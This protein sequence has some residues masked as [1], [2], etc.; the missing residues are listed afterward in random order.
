MENGKSATEAG[1]LEPVPLVTTVFHENILS[2][3]RC[4][5]MYPDS[6]QC[7]TYSS[8]CLVKNPTLQDKYSAF[9][10]QKK[11]EGYTER[12]LEES[13]GF[14][15]FDEEIKAKQLCES[16]IEVDQSALST[17]GDPSKGV[18]ISKYSDCLDLNPWYHGKTGFIV[19]FRLTKGRVKEVTE[20]YTQNFTQP[21]VGFDCHI[22][23]QI[24]TVSAT[25]S[26][27]LAYERTQ[28]YVY[29]L[30]SGGEAVTRPRQVCPFAVIRFSYGKTMPS[31]TNLMEQRY[32]P[33][34]GVFQY[35]LWQ[36][37]LQIHSVT[38]PVALRSRCD[39]LLP[40][41]LPTT[42]EMS[43]SISVSDLKQ[44]LLQSNFETCF[45][46]E[47]LRGNGCNFYTIIPLAD[48]DKHTLLSLELKDKDLALVLQ[49]KD[50]GFLV[51]LHSSTFF[52]YEDT[53]S[54]QEDSLQALFLFPDSR[55]VQKDTKS[56]WSKSLLSPE[57][58][59]ALPGFSYAVTKAE[60]CPLNQQ[61]SISC[62]VEQHLQSYA[63]L[64]QP[65]MHY[66]PSREISVFPDQ[67][68]VP[69]VIGYLYSA[70]KWTETS[71]LQ[72]L[73][74]FKQPGNYTLPV[75][76]VTELLEAGRDESINDQGNDIYY[77]L[78]SPENAGVTSSDFC[79]NGGSEGGFRKIP[80]QADVV[81]GSATNERGEFWMNE[82][83]QEGMVAEVESI[84]GVSQS[85]AP[86]DLMKC[87]GLGIASFDHTKKMPESVTF[88]AIGEATPVQT[89]DE[90]E[91][92]T[93]QEGY[94]TEASV[95][96]VSSTEMPDLRFVQHS[97]TAQEINSLP[98]TKPGVN[99]SFKK[100]SRRGRR[101]RKRGR[102]ANSYPQENCVEALTQPHLP[103]RRLYQYGLKTI[104]TD[105]GK[106]FVPHG[107]EIPPGDI[108][109]MAEMG[110]AVAV[111]SN[112]AQLP[113]ESSGISLIPARNAHAQDLATGTTDKRP[114]LTEVVDE[115]NL[116][117][118]TDEQDTVMETTDA[119]V[120]S[121]G[122][123]DEQT[124]YLETVD[125]QVIPL[126]I[127]DRE[128]MPLNREEGLYLKA[129]KVL[130][131]TVSSS[132]AESNQNK[133]VQQQVVPST[134]CTEKKLLGMTPT[135]ERTNGQKGKRKK[136]LCPI[137]QVSSLL[138]ELRDLPGLSTTELRTKR[139]KSHKTANEVENV[140]VNC[141]NTIAN[142]LKSDPKLRNC[143]SFD[144]EI[145][146]VS[147]TEGNPKTRA[148]SRKSIPR[149]LDLANASALSDGTQEISKNLATPTGPTETEKLVKP[150]KKRLRHKIT[151]HMKENGLLSFDTST[152]YGSDN[153]S[154]LQAQGHNSAASGGWGGV[155]NGTS[156]VAHRSSETGPCQP[157]D[158]LSMLADL[159]LSNNG[160]KV[161]ESQV[162][163]SKLAV[164]GQDCGKSMDDGPS[165]SGSVLSKMP[166]H[167]LRR[168]KRQ[169]SKQKLPARSPSPK[170]LV[171]TGEN[172]LV[173]SE[174]HSYSLSP[175]CLL[176]GLSGPVLQ[177]PHLD[178]LDHPGNNSSDCLPTSKKSNSSTSCQ[179]GQGGQDV[180]KPSAES[181]MRQF[182]PKDRRKRLTRVRQVKEVYGSLKVSRVW[183]EKYEFHLDSKYTNNL[184]EKAVMR[185]LHGPWDYSIEETFEQIRLIL[186]MWIGLF[187]SRS[188][189]RFFEID[190]TGDILRGPSSTDG[191]HGAAPDPQSRLSVSEVFY[192]VPSP[193]PSPEP[194]ALDLRE[195]RKKLTD[196]ISTHSDV[197]DLSYNHSQVLDL[198]ISKNGTE[199]P[200]HEVN[201]R[202]PLK[203]LC[204]LGELDTKDPLQS[205]YVTTFHLKVYRGRANMMSDEENEH[206]DDGSSVHEGGELDWQ[207][208][209]DSLRN[210]TAYNKLCDHT[211][212]ICI[213]S[214]K[215]LRTQDIVQAKAGNS[216]FDCQFEELPVKE[217][218]GTAEL[219]QS[220]TSYIQS[221]KFT[222][223]SFSP[224]VA[225]PSVC[226]D[227]TK[228]DDYVSNTN[229]HTDFC[230]VN[231]HCCKAL[232]VMPANSC[233]DNEVHGCSS[234]AV[235]P[236]K[237]HTRA[238][239]AEVPQ[240][241]K[242]NTRKKVDFSENSS[243]ESTDPVLE[244]E[245]YNRSV[246]ADKASPPVLGD[247]SFNHE[248]SLS[249]CAYI[250][251][252][253][254][255][256]A[257]TWSSSK[258]TLSVES[259][260]SGIKIPTSIPICD[261]AKSDAVNIATSSLQNDLKSYPDNFELV[262]S[263]STNAEKLLLSD[264]QN[265]A[266]CTLSTTEHPQ[267]GICEPY[268]FKNHDLTDFSALSSLGTLCS[269]KNGKPGDQSSPASCED[270][271][272]QKNFKLNLRDIL[273][274]SDGISSFN[275]K[276]TATQDLNSEIGG[277][278]KSS[279]KSAECQQCC[280]GVSSA[281][282]TTSFESSSPSCKATSADDSSESRSTF[283]P[284][285]K[286]KSPAPKFGPHLHF[287]G[288]SM[289]LSK[290]LQSSLVCMGQP[291]NV[292]EQDP[293]VHSSSMYDHREDS[294]E[295]PRSSAVDRNSVM[296]EQMEFEVNS[297]YLT[298]APFHH[299]HD[300]NTKFSSSEKLSH[301][302]SLDAS[303]F[304]TGDKNDFDPFTNS[305]IILSDNWQL[306]YQETQSNCSVLS[307]K[308]SLQKELSLQTK[309][310][311]KKNLEEKS[312]RYHTTEKIQPSCSKE[313]SQIC[314]YDSASCGTHPSPQDILNKAHSIKHCPV[315]AVKPSK[316]RE[317][318]GG[319]DICETPQCETSKC[320][321]G[322]EGWVDAEARLTSVDQL[323]KCDDQ[324]HVEIE[325]GVSYDDSG[326][327]E[328]AQ[329]S[330]SC[331]IDHYDS[332]PQSNMYNPGNM[333]DFSNARHCSSLFDQEDIN[334]HIDKEMLD[335]SKENSGCFSFRK[336]ELP[337]TSSTEGDRYETQ[338]SSNSKNYRKGLLTRTLVHIKDEKECSTP[339]LATS[340][341]TVLDSKGRRV[342]Y[343]NC[344]T[345]K[346]VS[347]RHVRTIQNTNMV[348]SPLQNFLQKWE[349]MH[350]TKP[351]ITQDT[352]D[353]EYLIFSEKMNQIL[354]RNLRN[355]ASCRPSRY[356][357]RHQLISNADTGPCN[358]PG[359]ERLSETGGRV[360][361]DYH[362][363]QS[364]FTKCKINMDFTK[365]T[366]SKELTSYFP[367][368][369]CKPPWHLDR[370][371]YLNRT[372]YVHPG[373]SSIT[374]ECSSSYQTVM[375][376]ICSSRMFLQ[377]AKKPKMDSKFLPQEMSEQP[378]LCCQTKQE[379][380]TNLQEQL[381][382]VVRQ[383][384]KTKFRFYILVT[385]EDGFFE[386]TKEVLEA[387]GHVS[388]DPEQFEVGLQ[389]TAMPL[390]I[391]L[392]NEDIAEYICTIP[393]LL[394]L[395]K[396][397]SV[398]FA[399]I[400]QPDDVLNLT[401]QELFN[402][403]G[404]VVCDSAMLDSLMLDNMKTLIEFLEKLSSS[405]KWTWFLHYRDCRLFKEK[406]RTSMD[407]KKRKQF[408]DWCQEAGIVETLPYH[409]CDILSGGQPDYLSCLLHLQA[410]HATARFAVFITDTPD[411][412]FGMYGIFVMKI[413]AFLQIY[414]NNTGKVC[415][416]VL[417][418]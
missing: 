305:K 288:S 367:F 273:P 175:S 61:E 327:V 416:S 85:A 278:H 220:R 244:P 260:S 187:Y 406:Q 229:I 225:A 399:G 355:T 319:D 337:F 9:C 289:N 115:Q 277:C 118:Q 221:C 58:I 158:A 351:D 7:F 119:Q 304:L 26:S 43:N 256:H 227:N 77:C 34:T 218:Q 109:F 94:S 116:P 28:Y 22:S 350:L 57:I 23:E 108:K 286:P 239:E 372:N 112:L 137:S 54:S 133:G 188:T 123:V 142:I 96:N 40:A 251:A 166:R 339:A 131:S 36:G 287:S 136:P 180:T 398:L 55:L 322:M 268:T 226:G 297:R 232:A 389:S 157:P 111:E 364:P 313:H 50:S 328:T 99:A 387:E 258:A 235:Q 267:G 207:N 317:C 383:S 3:L 233:E 41:Q 294:S 202:E 81:E 210:D 238:L 411:D 70:P 302:P 409:E 340:I 16:G 209:T 404:F 307:R 59:K 44:W 103:K 144:A 413:N 318:R 236:D 186:H 386:Q 396:T 296:S 410:Q 261:Q 205:S 213:A 301:Q 113:A 357:W 129:N 143:L 363:T 272:E 106:I 14:L 359:I 366:G 408:L 74:Y 71:H 393:R 121:T 376:D 242:S 195:E 368:V 125:G 178:L 105:C 2:P 276:L 373:V 17:L 114:L 73:S 162:P 181:S 311:L 5:Y 344:P 124:Q 10:T 65:G 349:K 370:L 414:R 198:T 169:I 308:T 76:R 149:K 281:N 407:A 403:G 191:L 280:D 47:V 385:S 20:N 88:T 255:N 285:S 95:T 348:D 203:S 356:P 49:L 98:H 176:L 120:S 382:I 168:H 300:L 388:V 29:E 353:L 194:K 15:M 401:H 48:Q 384:F 230:D 381:N 392:R 83:L 11:K 206:S 292:S 283:I 72:M 270:F 35:I 164:M 52:T 200:P 146:Q 78:S 56:R 250:V 53:L 174:E 418:L 271:L 182:H 265:T 145:E 309:N 138:E 215:L 51:L 247:P 266:S 92:I 315:M 19:L 325:E 246:Y 245:S 329:C 208:S 66:S 257:E 152:S 63:T 193:L 139:S 290:N 211:A 150:L 415:E 39:A 130:M 334:K 100:T 27:F 192:T 90:Q 269:G 332:G 102:T 1:L 183:K 199:K 42:L 282:S 335:Y 4:S 67:Y 330:T 222:H 331:S 87:G 253:L 295:I 141:E 107:S 241:P 153:L 248:L 86:V 155:I 6:E 151:E 117:I 135:L 190:P 400:D 293:K 75:T 369:P 361:K 165:M 402:K 412:S 156:F 30:C 82:Q 380:L 93:G 275:S 101:K 259:L 231:A 216:M 252:T 405:G 24:D 91:D 132:D 316:N 31:A 262:S 21:S 60:K 127:T 417:F 89:R 197:L 173:I 163:G 362:D 37:Q 64:F 196:P 243:D 299:L 25:T 310:D 80:D 219:R 12:E 212:N 69:D 179:D 161:L 160:D 379:M 170:G 147:K 234:D 217:R 126:N 249:N 375:N 32:S 68:D 185:A 38:I 314:E 171:V 395:K 321:V 140:I 8:A 352:M 323:S 279:H 97:F 365:K 201:E 346:H 13:F 377:H 167:S 306:S 312:K 338:W 223:V 84:A 347:S 228:K 45:T 274:P 62:V 394:E 326:N 320:P 240:Y 172:A 134:N 391:I 303:G 122:I 345:V 397:P 298:D 18:Y 159:A 341:I 148:R 378:D 343:E 104:I 324:Q 390:L 371:S 291:T 79:A 360:S 154:Q 264:C 284:E 224:I 254:N 46:S 184:L 263:I 333:S 177:V 358:S 354:K 342:I 237:F 336:E 204:K 214:E 110:R 128:A 189:A 33:K 374:A